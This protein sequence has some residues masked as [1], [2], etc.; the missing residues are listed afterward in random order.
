MRCHVERIRDP[1]AAVPQGA[2]ADKRE[3]DLTS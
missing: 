1:V 3:E 2:P